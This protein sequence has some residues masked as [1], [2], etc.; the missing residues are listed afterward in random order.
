MP[1]RA[2][3]TSGMDKIDNMFGTSLRVWDAGNRAWPMTWNQPGDDMVQIEA[4][5]DGTPTR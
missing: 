3:R 2:V 4:R 1:R 5:P